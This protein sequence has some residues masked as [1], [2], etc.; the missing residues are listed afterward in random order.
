MNSTNQSKFTNGL[1]IALRKERASRRIYLALANKETN[2]N[3]RNALVSLAET[4][5]HHSEKWVERL[6][7]LAVAL[8]TNKESLIERIW[9]WVLVQSGTDNALKRIE[10][11]E[12]EDTKM[13]EFLSQ[14]APTDGDRRI[15]QAGKHDE[16]VHSGLCKKK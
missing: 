14:I 8:P 12:E 11:N 5:Y 6:L 7:D 16:Q 3:R 1:I 9:R 13:Y 15:I 4:E 2:E 10:S